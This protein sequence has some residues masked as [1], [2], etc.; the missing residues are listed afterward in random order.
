MP[1]PA[2]FAPIDFRRF[3][4]EDLPALLT[5]HRVA[6]G[7][8]A[9]HLRGLAIRVGADAFTYLSRGG[10]LDVV[11]GDG[12]AETTVEIDLDAWQGLVHELEAPAGLIYAGRV[13]CVR[14]RAVELM[15]WETPLRVLY[16][17][18][19]P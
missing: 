2:A 3:H 1:L 9:A 8:A 4:R 12:A 18:R 16:H 5:S 19:T 17:G 14:G 7:R 13:R 10:T 6:A 11:D 15:E